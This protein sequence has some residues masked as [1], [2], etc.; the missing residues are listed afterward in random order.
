M[1]RL[2]PQEQKS[3]S[4]IAQQPKNETT[5]IQRVLMFDLAGWSNNDIAQEMGYTPAWISTIQNCP[6][7]MGLKKDRMSALQ[8][9]VDTGVAERVVAGDPVKEKIKALAIDAINIQETLMKNAASEFVRAN[10]ADKILDRAGYNTSKEKTV[11]SVEVTEKMASRF[12]RVLGHDRN[13][14]DG[15]AGTA[16]YRIEK[17]VSQ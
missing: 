14:D 6:M 11:L 17:E 13:K 9:R 12:E 2:V 5:T 4:T 3:P 15:N 16:T 10:V 8:D 1:P 7:Y